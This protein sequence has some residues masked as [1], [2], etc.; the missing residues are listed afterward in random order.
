M[1]VYINS[2]AESLKLLPSFFYCFASYGKIFYILKLYAEV[3][4]YNSEK[5]GRKR[6]NQNLKTTTLPSTCH[7]QIL[8]FYKVTHF[9]PN[10]EAE[11]S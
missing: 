1:K 11:A 6:G 3:K 8:L 2:K 10:S 4:K 5:K 7:T 9:S